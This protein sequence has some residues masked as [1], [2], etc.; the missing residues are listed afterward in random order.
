M[1]IPPGF[2]LSGFERKVYKLNKALY[3]LKQSPGAWTGIFHMVMISFGYTHS[4]VD[5]I[6]FI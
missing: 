4:N 1:S 5:H 3:G 6:L 2:V